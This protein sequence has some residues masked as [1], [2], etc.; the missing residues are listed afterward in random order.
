MLLLLLLLNKEGCY[1][2]E[3]DTIAMKS[4][5]VRLHVIF[6]RTGPSTEKMMATALRYAF[7]EKFGADSICCIR[8]VSSIT[9]S[10]GS[11]V[12]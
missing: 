3:Y 11:C 5:Q 2:C 7:T 1:C 6:T 4:V 8:N 10:L 9:H 12:S